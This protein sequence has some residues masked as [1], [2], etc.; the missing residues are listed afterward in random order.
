MSDQHDPGTSS[1]AAPLLR[2]A[3]LRFAYGR[4]V[5]LRDVSFEVDD[6]EL[7]VLA[8]RN[9]AGKSTLL[10]CIAGWT[11]VTSGRVLVAGQP[12]DEAEREARRH[13]ILVPD[14]PVFYDALT[15]W[16]HLRLVAGANHVAGWEAHAREMLEHFGLWGDRDDFPYT[17][18]RGMR[19][20]LALCLAL[21]VEPALLLLDEPLGPLDPVSADQLWRDLGVYRDAGMSILLSSHQLPG[22][23]QPDRYL[24]MEAGEVVGDGSPAE[25]RERLDLPEHATLDVLLRAA[26]VDRGAPIGR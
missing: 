4:D 17:Y 14:L 15:A 3:K 23:V 13:L 10:R 24:L 11:T 2:V 5:I 9:G 21:L 8:G 26:L 20:K 19:Y 16:E 7:I 18:S 6:G 25:L 22:D 1:A 12:L